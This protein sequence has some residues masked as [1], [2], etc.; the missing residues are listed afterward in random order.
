MWP[1]GD[2]YGYCSSK[3]KVS[4]RLTRFAKD[5]KVTYVL[6][7]T[8]K[9]VTKM[10]LF[11]DGK[12]VKSFPSLE[13]LGLPAN[14]DLHPYAYIGRKDDK[15]G[16]IHDSHARRPTAVGDNG[17]AAL[18]KGCPLLLPDKLLSDEKGDAFLA[19]VAKQVGVVCQ[20]L[21]NTD[22]KQVH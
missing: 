10:T 12:E 21:V 15:V 4:H 7:R 8:D 20:G 6:D 14:T 9:A 5:A 22:G 17:L 11:I 13:T 18:V 16:L 2:L 1:S 3:S 19:A